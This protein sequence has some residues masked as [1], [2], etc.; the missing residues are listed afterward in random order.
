MG[1]TK[2]SLEKIVRRLGV[3]ISDVRLLEQALTHKSYLGELREAESNER[4][5]FLGDSVL[6]LV[7]AQYLYQQF[8]DRPEGELA[9]AKAVAVSEPVLAESARQLGLSEFILMSSGE[10][11]SGGRERPS[12]LADVFEAVIAAIY[13]D[14]GLE[15]VRRFILT[16]LESILEDI[17]RKEH[18]RDYKTLLQ[19]HTQGVYKKT[20][21]Y[22]VVNEAGADHDKTFTVEARLGHK[23]LGRGQGKSKKQAEQAAALEALKTMDRWSSG[24]LG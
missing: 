22:V 24:D 7:V 2:R 4:L 10:E 9:K 16:S 11:A 8:P 17:E 13:L 20:P 6:G 5:E 1:L 12:I 21:H 19:E 18:I 23:T 15:A 14:Q 3:S